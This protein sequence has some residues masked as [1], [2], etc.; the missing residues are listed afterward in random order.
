MSHRA[1]LALAAFLLVACSSVSSPTEA[2][3]TSSM[4]SI[5]NTTPAGLPVESGPIVLRCSDAAR[6]ITPPDPAA[7]VIA[8]I[9]ATFLSGRAIEFSES[10]STVTAGGRQYLASKA[11][12]N[13][14][15]AVPETTV[16]VIG[17]PDAW[18]YY[19][20]YAIWTSGDPHSS[21]VPNGISKEF[22]LGSCPSG[23]GPAGY[24]GEILVADYSCV[25]L[26]ISGDLPNDEREVRLPVGVPS[27][28]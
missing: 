8:G 22:I 11:F 13:V 1:W 25:V 21:H 20:R 7:P 17:P 23:S 5:I 15:A 26:G 16:R 24:T 3:P 10:P 14:V 9:S 4:P 12:V 6:G 18:L 2:H 19:T 27:C 28:A